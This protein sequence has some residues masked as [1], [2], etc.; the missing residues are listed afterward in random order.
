MCRLFITCLLPDLADLRYSPKTLAAPSSRTVISDQMV[1]RPNVLVFGGLDFLLSSLIPQLVPPLPAEALISHIRIIDKYLV[2]PPTTLISK[3]LL[4]LLR[5][6]SDTIE[7]RQGNLTN[8]DVVSKSFMDPAPNGLPYSHI[9]DLTGDS[10]PGRPPEIYVQTTLNVSL[11]IA[12]ASAAQLSR[13]P[14]SIKAHIRS[15]GPF[16]KHPDPKKR[17][18]EDDPEGWKP[19]DMRAVWWHET[20]RAIGSIPGLPLVILRSSLLY[21]ETYTRFE[22]LVF[23]LLGLVYKHMDEDMKLLWSPDLP[24]NCINIYDLAGAIWKAAEWV[25]TKTR[26]EADALAGSPIPPSYDPFVTTSISPD[27]V[28]A[29]SGSVVVPVFNMVD[30]GDTTQARIA[31]VLS[32]TYGI[33]VEFAE[34]SDE[35]FSGMTMSDIVE[36]ANRVHLEAWREIVARS[37]PP[38]S[39]APLSPYMPRGFI[40]EEYAYGVDGERAKKVLGYRHRYPRMNKQ[41]IHDYIN[42]CRREGIW[43]ETD[44]YTAQ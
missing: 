35:V 10:M 12:R 14:G 25:S 20:L 19:R 8:P 7:Y 4:G 13:I 29:T 1:A 42:W 28:L 37:N 30:E 33:N 31:E 44:L 21:G 18:K 9:I 23:I 15:T 41:A 39:H 24:K 3:E 32:E 22:T 34:L 2:D 40:L 5:G 6:R 11:L 17:Y 26:K 27:V 16:Y 36:E 43:P 38:L